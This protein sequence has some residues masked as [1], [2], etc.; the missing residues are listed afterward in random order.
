MSDRTPSCAPSRLHVAAAIAITLLALAPPTHAQPIPGLVELPAD[1]TASNGDLARRR[2]AL[3]QERA[4]LHSQ[5]E[6]L[7]ARCGSVAVGSAAEAA[8]QTDQ[9]AL[10]A[11]LRQHV[12]QSNDFNAAAQAATPANPAQPTPALD[13]ESLRV[14]NGI[15]ALARRQG[16]SSERLARLDANLRALDFGDPTATPEQIRETW[17]EILGRSGDAE[18]A[19][20]ASADGGL[21]FAAAGTQAHNDC[22]IFALA[23]ATGRP[24]GWVAASAAELIRQGEWRT[25]D[26]R[27][28]PQN[29]IESGGLNGGEVVMLAEVL[30]EAEITPS[31]RF[32]DVLAHGRQVVVGV[33]PYDGEN[34]VG[35]EIVLDKAFQ[36]GGETWYVIIDSNRGPMER[37]F[38]RASEVNVLLRDNGIAFSPDPGGSP[39]LLRSR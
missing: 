16:W 38:A 31:S 1:V 12:Q 15:E 6:A 13:G 33:A 10:L 4:R 32:A 30:G 8:C 2:A 17:R 24:Y 18:L 28:H 35:H 19:R 26:E 39:R 3:E 7:N 34:A 5:I 37:L 21:G 27:A 14:I 9:A 11:A 25:A 29:A 23:N 22:A 20:E 36:H